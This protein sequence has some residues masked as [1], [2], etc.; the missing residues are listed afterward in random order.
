MRR[1]LLTAALLIPLA[2][3][4][5]QAETYAGIWQGGAPSTVTFLSRY[6][7]KYCYFDQCSDQNFSGNKNKQI[8]FRWGTARYELTRTNTGYRGVFTNIGDPTDI[9][10]FRLQK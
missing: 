7:L 6:K 4:A 3:P 5:V 8:L 10:D 2:A 9:I 1:L